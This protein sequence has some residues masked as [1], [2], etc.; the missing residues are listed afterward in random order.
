MFSGAFIWKIPISVQSLQRQE[1]RIKNLQEANQHV[2]EQMLASKRCIAKFETETLRLQER[3]RSAK[4]SEDAHREVLI[5][6]ACKTHLTP[7]AILFMSIKK[8]VF[9]S[10]ND[11]CRKLRL[12]DPAYVHLRFSAALL[13]SDAQSLL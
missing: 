3:Q 10:G 5:R 11:V 4:E 13:Q 1:M 8:T 12:T 9:P 7:Q 6:Y 2:E